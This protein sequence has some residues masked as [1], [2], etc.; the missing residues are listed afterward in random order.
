MHS[1]LRRA[2]ALCR[3][4]ASD[5]G[6]CMRVPTPGGRLADVQGTTAVGDGL[7]PSRYPGNWLVRRGRPQRARQG[8]RS[9][10]RHE[11]RRVEGCFMRAPHSRPGA[12]HS[13]CA[14]FASGPATPTC[15]WNRRKP[16]GWPRRRPSPPNSTPRPEG[17]PG[18]CC[19]PGRKPRDRRSGKPRP[20]SF[21]GL[22]HYGIG[23]GLHALWPDQGPFEQVYGMCMGNKLAIN[24]V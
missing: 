23:N 24:R 4:R 13:L 7:V 1:A 17:W 16:D 6:C 11:I 12:S 18:R 2:R 10:L 8:A 21:L 14:G 22:G 15:P 19:G 20:R 3:A 5:G 9:P